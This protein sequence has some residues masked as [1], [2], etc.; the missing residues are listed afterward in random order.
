MGF[1]KVAIL[2]DGGFF[3]QRFKSIHKRY[4]DKSDVDDTIRH[5]LSLVALKNTCYKL[6][7]DVLMRTFYYDCKPF[8]KTLENPAGK[9][10]DFSKSKTYKRQSA[11]LN[12]IYS[13]DQLAM[14]LGELAFSG[15]KIT[16]AKNPLP[17][18]RQKGVDMKIGLD[19]AWMA[20]KRTVDKIVLVTG[21]SDFVAPMKLARRE[22]IQ[23][24]L[25]PMEHKLTVDL[26]TH[27]DF[28]IG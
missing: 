6:H 13:I 3:N 9:P 15:W 10:I 1:N 20:G 25:Y 8:D 17:D 4:P 12:S 5:I 21:D 19:I 28:V 22:G 23:I 16:A 27:A 7:P 26:I 14:R 11:F 24:F 2:I 18:F